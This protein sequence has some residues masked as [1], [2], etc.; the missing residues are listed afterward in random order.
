MTT[1]SYVMR[2]DDH[3]SACR[4]RQRIEIDYTNQT[5][6]SLLKRD[7]EEVSLSSGEAWRMLVRPKASSTSSC[8]W[9]P[10]NM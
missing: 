7:F 9:M 6:F 10:C 4:L 8:L 2:T 5:L 3:F 1:E